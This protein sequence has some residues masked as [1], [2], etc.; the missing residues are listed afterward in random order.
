MRHVLER[1]LTKIPM[2]LLVGASLG[3][4][5][6]YSLVL[7]LFGVLAF[8]PLALLVSLL[9]CGAVSVGSSYVFGK[10]YGAHV[11]L[12][13]AL[14]TALIL[15]F[16]FTPS[17]SGIAILELALIAVIAQAS[18]FVI[19]Y[20]QRHIFNPAAVGAVAGGLLH[21]QFATWWVATPSLLVPVLLVGFVVLY[22]VRELRLGGL[23]LLVSLVLLSIKGVAVWTA[24]G[25][26]PLLFL[27]GIML[28][29]PVTLPPRQWQKY[30]V[31]IVVAIIVSF[32]FNIGWFYSS[33]GVALL[34]GNGLAFGLA[35]EQRRGLRLILSGRRQVTPTVE[36]FTLTSPTPIVFTAGQYIELT[37]PHAHQDLR[38]TRRMFSVTS[39]PGE[40]EVRFASKFYE[41]SSSF[42]RQLR[43]LPTGT[44]VQAT[45]ITGNFVLPNNT[46]QKLLFIAGGIGI[47]PFIS[48]IESQGAGRDIVV[49][50]FMRDP[51]EAAYQDVLDNSSARV[52]YFVRQDARGEF[53]TASE[54]TEAL[55]AEYVD[56]ASER[57]A[58]ISG[59]PQM[60]TAAQQFLKP[61]VHRIKTDY[62]NG[63]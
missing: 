16:L 37:V 52:H 61:H 49:L 17:L 19:T 23:F 26:W 34:I 60:V 27:A 5:A 59:P 2:Y 10:L 55:L 38:G 28:S 54:L 63:Y 53:G 18:K 57:T 43:A 21:L 35:F 50:Y 36:E 3:V 29:E 8:S 30:I 1:Y 32:P 41:P 33:P 31:A 51:S 24:L 13:S 39:M 25:S 58:Y 44:I 40:S 12:P 42:K 47:T 62:F 14:I 20:K 7:A 9:V 22:K 56:D 45:G 48:H 6:L 11:H 46:A 4:L 15:S